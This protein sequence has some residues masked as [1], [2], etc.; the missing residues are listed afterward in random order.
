MFLGE[1][2]PMTLTTQ[3]FIETKNW[4][5]KQQRAKG[6]T[7]KARTL[8]QNLDNLEQIAL[9][10]L[11]GLRI[12]GVLVNNLSVKTRLKIRLG[13]AH[14]N[15]F[16]AFVDKLIEQKKQKGYEYKSFKSSLEL[17]KAFDK[18]LTFEKITIDFYH[19]LIAFLLERNYKLNYINS[20]IKNLKFVMRE[21]LQYSLH[22][23]LD[24]Q[25][26]GF[27][28]IALGKDYKLALT[29]AEI[30][31]IYRAD[32]PAALQKIRDLFVLACDTGLRYQSWSELNNKNIQEHHG[33]LMFIILTKKTQKKIAVPASPRSLEIL[34]RNGG[35]FNVIS[36]SL[37]NKQLKKI[38]ALAGLTNEVKI[39]EQRKEGR[40]VEVPVYSLITTHTARRSF[41]TNLKK[42][43]VQDADIMKMT[44]HQNLK[45]LMIYDQET[46]IENAAKI[47]G[48]GINQFIKVV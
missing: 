13:Y 28:K 45:T 14:Q 16:F 47:G 35:Q 20:V 31:K 25:R 34:K 18:N 9:E 33:Q 39:I 42:N 19:E 24:F 36:N 5:N 43:R 3:E 10:V 46:E 23:N 1:A 12:D 48:L 21:A 8:N 44:G 41:I 22:R 38:G 4:D 11:R 40:V 7:G 29:P 26:K 30:Q 15:T 32:V 17:L 6:R 2:I 27:K 37:M